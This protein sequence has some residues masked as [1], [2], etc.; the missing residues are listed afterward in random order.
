[1]AP[2]SGAW[3]A[4]GPVA[5]ADPMA[6]RAALKGPIHFWGL[7]APLS[8]AGGWWGQWGVSTQK[9]GMCLEK[10]P[11]GHQS[12]DRHQISIG[13][14]SQP[15]AFSPISS[16]QPSCFPE[17]E[18][19]HPSCSLPENLFWGWELSSTLGPDRLQTRL[20]QTGGCSGSWGLGSS[21]PLRPRRKTTPGL[22]GL[23]YSSHMGLH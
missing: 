4:L 8:G 22:G 16:Q 11:S 12:P 18:L 10:L 2:S 1:M 21:P 13:T 14:P 5:A 7:K 9:E 19:P 15:R 3:A 23:G 6:W 20:D 17:W